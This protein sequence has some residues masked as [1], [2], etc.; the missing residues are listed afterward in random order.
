MGSG[1]AV[2]I[3]LAAEVS[4]GA[5]A[6]AFSAACSIGSSTDLVMVSVGLP[7]DVVLFSSERVCGCWLGGVLGH[8]CGC[9]AF[10]GG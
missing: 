8:V 7:A 2:V 5:G 3:G 9:G 10:G 1:V 4:V 6:Q